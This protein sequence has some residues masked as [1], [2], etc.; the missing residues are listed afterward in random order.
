MV[1]GEEFFTAR[2]YSRYLPMAVFILCRGLGHASVIDYRTAS[3]GEGGQSA[4]GPSVGRGSESP[5]A[6][7]SVAYPVVCLPAGREGVLLS[8]YLVEI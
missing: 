3:R 1:C 7:L 5:F 2:R 8:F 6:G 4:P